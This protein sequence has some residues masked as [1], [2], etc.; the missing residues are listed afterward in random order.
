V[1]AREPLRRSLAEVGRRMYAAGLVAGADGNASVRVGEDRI[2]VTPAGVAKGR[3]SPEDLVLV[4]LEGR[5]VGPGRPSSELG[6]HLAVYRRR[7]GVSAAV[8]AHPPWTIAASLQERLRFDFAP[9]AVV[10]LGRVARCAYARPGTPAVAESLEPYLEDHDSFVL[11]RHGSLTVGRDL[12]EA[13][14]RLEALEHNSKIALLALLGGDLPPLPQLE[15]A[16]L[17]GAV[18]TAAGVAGGPAHPVRGGS[19]LRISDEEPLVSR[20]RPPER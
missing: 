14:L 19:S 9:E 20:L 7:P 8:H 12:E 10:A 1:R 17:R 6:M 3:L 4:D 15:I 16:E 5:A 13:Y 11:A 18:S 2:L